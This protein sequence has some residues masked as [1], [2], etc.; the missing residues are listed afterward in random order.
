MNS[1]HFRAGV[2]SCLGDAWVSCPTESQATYLVDLLGTLRLRAESTTKRNQV[3]I[4]LKPPHE[5]S[6]C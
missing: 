3:G 4:K 2:Y 6:L 1:L 5:Y